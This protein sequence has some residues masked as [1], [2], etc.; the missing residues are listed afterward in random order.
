MTHTIRPPQGNR[1]GRQIGLFWPGRYRGKAVSLWSEAKRFTANVVIPRNRHPIST[2]AG[3]ARP[4][5]S[6]R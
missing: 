2:A 6:V 4:R 3:Y 1:E 5:P